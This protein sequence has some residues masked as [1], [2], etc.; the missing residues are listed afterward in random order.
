MSRLSRLAAKPK[1]V[2]ID[3]EVFTLHPLTVSDMPLIMSVEKDP[4]KVKD[5][6][7]KTLQITDSDV[8]IE[9]INNMSMENFKKFSQAIMRVNGLSDKESAE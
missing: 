7:L 4:T 9:E 1:D 5:V 2:T 6:I 8:T 3:G